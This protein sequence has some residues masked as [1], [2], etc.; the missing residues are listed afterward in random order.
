MGARAS[1]DARA[2][3]VSGPTRQTV[4]MAAAPQTVMPVVVVHGGAGQ[5]VVSKKRSLR[6]RDA[7]THAV[8]AARAALGEGGSALDAVVEA[9]VVL[10]DCEL[11]NAGLGSVLTEDGEVEL[12]AAVMDGERRRAGAVAVV[13]GQPN[14]VRVARAVLDAGRHA[15]LAGPGAERF[16]RD[17]GFPDIAPGELLTDHRREQLADRAAGEAP[18]PGFGDPTP[19]GSDTVGAVVLD[20]AGHLAAATSTGGIAGKAAGR[21]GDSPLVGAGLYAQDGVCAVSA[22]GT[23]ER[24]IEAVV[25]HEVSARIR[26]KGATVQRAVE[27]A[28]ATVGGDVGLIAIDGRGHVGL[29]CTTPVF[30]RALAIGDGPVRTGVHGA[31][32]L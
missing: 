6:L 4:A 11:F 30:Q 14:P 25:A 22:T 3:V 18:R 21:V 10:E 13:R 7:L 19:L 31:E 28:C 5:G 1:A 27:D 20:A 32:T 24:L 17:A 8:D 29:S 16:A 12:D 9:V 23:G 26:L 15:L 2:L